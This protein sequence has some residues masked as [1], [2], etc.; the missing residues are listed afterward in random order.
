MKLERRSRKSGV[1]LPSSFPWLSF[2]GICSPTNRYYLKALSGGVN[3]Y[4]WHD[5]GAENMQNVAAYMASTNGWNKEGPC[6][7]VTRPGQKEVIPD[8][9]TLAERKMIFFCPRVYVDQSGGSYV[10][11]LSD[12]ASGKNEIK[13]DGSAFLDA[14]NSPAATL[15]HE[16]THLVGETGM[17][18]V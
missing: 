14:Y 11:T 4:A 18:R 17:F 2:Y 10:K 3:D 5:L 9:E 1:C 13:T 16:M 6:K 8:A 15:L 7:G 12:Y